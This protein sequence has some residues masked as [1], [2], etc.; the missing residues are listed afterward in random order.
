MSPS[1]VLIRNNESS[2]HPFMYGQQHIVVK[3]DGSF[4]VA[5]ETIFEHKSI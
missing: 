4:S 5:L 2:Y 1:E 3:P